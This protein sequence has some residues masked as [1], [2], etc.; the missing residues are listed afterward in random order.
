MRYS[1]I[2][3]SPEDYEDIINFGNYVF[4]IDF[5]SLL[6]KIY[7]NHKEIAQYHHILKE[8]NKIKAMVGSFPLGLTVCDNYLKGR[9]IGTV[10]VHRY[11][12]NFGYMRLLMDNAV[13]EI[14]AEGCDFAVLSGRRQ[15]Y[16]YWG[17]LLVVYT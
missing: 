5:P 10:S 17:L 14:K 6:P 15:R 7:N 9:G 3:G 8:D 11:S 2:K 13:A 16:E 4:N 12:R 1:I